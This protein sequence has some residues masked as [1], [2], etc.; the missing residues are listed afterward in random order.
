MILDDAD[1][2][3]LTKSRAMPDAM[4]SIMNER[5]WCMAVGR[6]VVVSSTLQQ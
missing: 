3:A 2:L 5:I 6:D 4:F 1:R